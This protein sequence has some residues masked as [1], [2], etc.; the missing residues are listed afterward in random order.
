[1][2]LVDVD[3]TLLLSFKFTYPARNP[4]SISPCWAG[5]NS[6]MHVINDNSQHMNNWLT[7]EIYND[8]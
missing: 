6:Y 4:T 1:M 5:D 8:K 2:V 7:E 3:R